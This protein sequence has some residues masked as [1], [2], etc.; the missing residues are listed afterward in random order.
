MQVAISMRSVH[1]LLLQEE[2]GVIDFLKYA[3]SLAVDGVEFDDMYVRGSHEKITELQDVL[4]ETGLQVSCYDIHHPTKP[5]QPQE[6]ETV[7]ESIKE[8]LAVAKLLGAQY[9]QIVGEVFE[10]EVVASDVEQLILDLV[11]MVLPAIHGSGLTLTVENPASAN[12]QSHQLAQ[13][14]ERIGD[15]QVKVGFNMA[16]SLVAGEDPLEAA[17][18]LK[19]HIA[20]VRAVDVRLAHQDEEPQSGIYVGCVVGLGLVPLKKLFQALQAQGY[21]GWIALEFTGLEDAHFGTEAS[22]KNLRQSLAELRHD[23]LH[24]GESTEMPL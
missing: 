10:P 13:L 21:E 11:E 20:L 6:R 2:M 3:A 8:E 23:V 4:R 9:V 5:L 15:P 12:F 14:L 17:E 22:L 24:P 18:C 19:D 1:G 16:N 7:L